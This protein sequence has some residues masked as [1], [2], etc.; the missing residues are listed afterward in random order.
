MVGRSSDLI[1]RLVAEL[2]PVS[3]LNPAQLVALT[4]L[5]LSLG[6]GFVVALLGVRPELL[7]LADTGAWPGLLPLLKPLMWVW[8]GLVGLKAV[9]ELSRPEG[10]LRAADLLPLGAILLSQGLG[11]ALAIVR[12]GW[13]LPFAHAFGQAG[14]CLATITGGGV[15]GLWVLHR[16]WLR[17]AA[18]SHPRLLSLMAAQAAAG[19][20][21]AVYALHCA[22]D[23]PVYIFCVYVPSVLMVMLGA[24]ALRRV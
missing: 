6:T 10:R 9:A 20:S 17:Q 7:R 24:A 14:L 13:Q 18:P 15:I 3:P 11:V 4:L 2:R 16:V 23:Q 21:A 8:A 12:M 22:M 1:A 19:L 5:G